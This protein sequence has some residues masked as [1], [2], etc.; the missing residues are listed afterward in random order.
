MKHGFLVAAL[1]LAACGTRG[2]NPERLLWKS[3]P[4]HHAQYFRLLERND[5]RAVVVFAE[6]GDTLLWLELGSA[7]ADRRSAAYERV[8]CLSTT[9]F[10]Y[11]SALGLTDRV[12]AAVD[13]AH[14]R[15]TAA[16]ERIR[17]GAI[18]ELS[19][20]D[21]V[22]RE[23]LLA[24]EVD[25]AFDYPF[26]KGGRSM[27]VLNTKMVPV[28]EY[29]EVHPLGRAEWLRFFGA[30]FGAE[31]KADSLYRSIAERYARAVV[32]DT[33]NRPTVVFGSYWQGQWFVPSGDSYMARL[34]ADAGGDYL[35]ADRRGASN[36]TLDL[37]SMISVAEQADRWGMIARVEGQPTISDLT[38]GDERLERMKAVQENGSFIC[39]TARSDLFG[40]A[41]LEPD[42]VL[43]DLRWIF[44][45]P[46]SDTAHVPK[47]FQR[48]PSR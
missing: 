6:N 23:R 37:E 25:I 13:L 3:L 29:L 1:A 41:I 12:K 26:G 21:G 36:I 47:Y 32:T 46:E 17:K 39:N 22:D 40:A 28:T 43:C 24:A 20:A 14:V 16:Q 42:A 35:F 33:S 44:R 2:P 15:D 8:A 38:T 11:L 48:I 27:Q 34:I 31:R 9:Y 4:N 7:D 18:S 10:P 5:E 19:G 45:Y 30:L